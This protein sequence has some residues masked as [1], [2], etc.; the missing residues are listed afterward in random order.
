M[1]HQTWRCK[2]QGERGRPFLN[3]TACLC[4]GLDLVL[5]CAGCWDAPQPHPTSISAAPCICLILR[6]EHHQCF[7][8]MIPFLRSHPGFSFLFLP[9]TSSSNCSLGGGRGGGGEWTIHL[10]HLTTFL[11][12]FPP[13]LFLSFPSPVTLKTS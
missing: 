3:H 9:A 6:P 7:L 1:H 10:V 12:F 13:L 5:G 4:P 8:S 11:L 2:I